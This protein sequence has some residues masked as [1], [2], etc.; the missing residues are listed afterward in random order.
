KVDGQLYGISLGA[1]SVAQ[2]VNLSAF[3]EAGI[4]PP[5]RDTTYDEIREKGEA[6][7]AANIRGGIRIISDGSGSEPMLDNWLRQKGL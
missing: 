2:L 7:K 3:E 6:F 4:E 1:N 5:N